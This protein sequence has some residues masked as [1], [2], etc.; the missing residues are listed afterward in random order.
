[1]DPRF[2]GD[3][4]NGGGVHSRGRVTPW[5]N[6]SQPGNHISETKFKNALLKIKQDNIM[7]NTRYFLALNRLHGLTKQDISVVIEHHENIDE[8]F[9]KNYHQLFSQKICDQIRT[10]D[11]SAVDTELNWLE[12]PNNHL[13]T[14]LDDTYPALLR[15]ISSPPLLL[16]VKGD[17]AILQKPQIAIVGS[18]N[19]T[20]M[21]YKTAK[22]FSSFFA[23]QGFV[24]T[25]GF[26]MGID[27]ASHEGALMSGQTIGVLGTG[28]DQI[29]PR[30]NKQLAERMIEQGALVSEFPLNTKPLRLNFPRR[31]RIISGLSLGVLVV[32]AAVRSGSLITAR[33]AL[34]QNREVFAIPGSIHNP[35][36]KGCHKL[37]QSGA[38]LVESGEDVLSEIK[39]LLKLNNELE[40]L[41]PLKTIKKKKSA[42]KLDFSG[43]DREY[44]SLLSCVG[45]ETTAIDTII[46]LSG[47]T[48]D[49]VSPML[50]K[51]ELMGFLVRVSGGY[52]KIK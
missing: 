13:V 41:L 24:I 36:S 38:K 29:Y 10:L 11:W 14:I 3:D 28:L 49:I 39:E 17:L 51:L 26:A 23:S 2:R 1:M 15:E 35:L 44:V 43:L 19:P 31:N 20:P 9:N 40:S 50:L 6:T 34:E 27:A 21:G 7:Q 48:P 47:L 37:I 42:E 45:F 4:E 22:E 5:R 32:E 30:R 33:L 52:S 8:I 16:F 12:K 18:R 46:L 25:S